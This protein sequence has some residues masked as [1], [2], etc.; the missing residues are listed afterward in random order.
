MNQIIHSLKK[1][2]ENKKWTKYGDFGHCAEL[3]TCIK[4]SIGS[5]S[6]WSQTR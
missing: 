6:R 3:E 2:E 1:K 5:A 4:S